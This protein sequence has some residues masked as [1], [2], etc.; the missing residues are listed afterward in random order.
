MI[1]ETHQSKPDVILDV[2]FGKFWVAK[3]KP[4]GFVRPVSF[5]EAWKVA[6]L[7]V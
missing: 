5:L 6:W 4:H 1:N 7:I 3:P 2:Q